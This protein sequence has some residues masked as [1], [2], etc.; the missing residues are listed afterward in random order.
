M[1]VGLT[2]KYLIIA[3][4]TLICYPN[5]ALGFITDDESTKN[6]H[7]RYSISFSPL[8]GVPKILNSSRDPS[9]FYGKWKLAKAYGPEY[10]YASSYLNQSIT[11]PGQYNG[12]HPADSSII[13]NFSDELIELNYSFIDSGTVTF[14]FWNNSDTL[15]SV[16]FSNTKISMWDSYVSF[17]AN[18]PNFSMNSPF[19]LVGMFYDGPLY[20]RY[21]YSYS[22]GPGSFNQQETFTIWHSSD[23]LSHYYGINAL[24]E[25]NMVNST[26]INF[27]NK[28][29][30]LD[31]LTLKFIDVST[32][33]PPFTIQDTIDFIFNGSLSF[34]PIE[35]S[36]DSNVKALNYYGI[37]NQNFQNLYPIQVIGNDME[38]IYQFDED[39]SG[40]EIRSRL[41]GDAGSGMIFDT[42]NFNWELEQ[43]SIKLLFEEQTTL[44]LSYGINS[45]TLIVNGKN[46]ICEHDTCYFS[47]N[48]NSFG[49][50]ATFLFDSYE[51]LLEHSI[52]L[53]DINA[54]H[55]KY[56]LSMININEHANLLIDESNQNLDI[57]TY[58][59]GLTSHQ[60]NFLNIGTD[61]L[62]CSISSP[63]SPWIVLPDSVGATPPGHFQDINFSING[64]MLNDFEQYNT[65]I[66]I[67]SNDYEDSMSVVHVDVF[68]N[69]PD[70]FTVGLENNNFNILE[71]DTLQ[72]EFYVVGPET[73]TTFSVFS[74]S[75]NISGFVVVDDEYI[76]NT[77]Q[78][79]SIKSKL[80][81]TP[82]PN[83]YGQANVYILAEN[84]YDYS[85]VDSIT[86]NV[87]NVID[88]IIEPEMIYP[89][90]GESIIFESSQD[91]IQFIWL[92]AEY[93][94]FEIGPEFEYRLRIVQLNDFSTTTYNYYDLMD[95]TFVFYPDSSSLTSSN[96][97]YVWTLYTY[98]QDLITV[99]DGQS[100]VFSIINSFVNILKDNFPYHYKLHS[101]YPNPFNPLTS[102]RYDLPNDGMVKITVHDMMG[103][104]VKTLVNSSQTAGF[105]SVQ[106]NA[107]NDKNEPVSAGIYLYTIQA[108]EL[109]QTKKMVL[110][111]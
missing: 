102:L 106:W 95:T 74:D 94:E 71:D 69:E 60:F 76:P 28:I 78:N 44:R 25:I 16:L 105:K 24:S 23:S 41:L 72:V 75:E 92:G 54:I 40:Y 36:I 7:D 9:N 10:L 30:S 98:Q 8:S 65:Q 55:N 2:K 1:E 37:F 11:N 45:D 85:H 58:S 33:Q 49:S 84:E 62:F 107:T 61:T 21:L 31:S 104:V 39:F 64:S 14:G 48:N 26:N 50:P 68:V 73:N 77:I 88:V 18:S 109:R 81:V 53:S 110:L 5:D 97:N 38:I 34:S 29:V 4:F 6:D 90:D 86:I 83:W 20:P 82:A 79:Y 59:V 67:H 15:S 52:E 93:P 99:L 66:F 51:D 96:T 17:Y 63:S 56:A 27:R 3:L 111:K 19:N 100:G 101:A 12:Y 47:L 91:S 46:T 43:D 32:N 89:P 70:L 80:F 22:W 87:E 13:L 42:T 57:T 103:R 35:V 108:G